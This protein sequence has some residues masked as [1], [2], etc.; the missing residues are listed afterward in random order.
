MQIHNYMEDIV[1]D[2]L[3][4]M[5]RNQKDV[6]EL[7]ENPGNRLDISAATLN[8]LMPKYVVTAKGRVYTK[9]QKLAAQFKADVIREI[10]K[11]IEIVKGN[12]R[13]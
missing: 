12:P 13:H 8:K 3:N 10:S 9:L 1:E 11:A 4:E 2:V 7:C 5:I 6:Q